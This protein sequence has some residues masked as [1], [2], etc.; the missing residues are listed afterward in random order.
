MTSNPWIRIVLGV[1]AVFVLAV[2]LGVLFLLGGDETEAVGAEPLVLREAASAI[3][4]AR[5]F[6]TAVNSGDTAEVAELTSTTPVATLDF[7]IGG[8]PYETL[9]C[10]QFE[11]SDECRL[12]SDGIADFT[13]VVDVESV[14]IDEITYVGGE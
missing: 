14:Q 1:L 9:D 11:G 4:I 7:L 2:A 13:F 3:D 8:G 5:G 10:Y 6:Q 12:V